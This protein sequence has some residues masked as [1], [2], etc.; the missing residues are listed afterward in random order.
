MVV[1][2]P[3][4]R[5][6]LEGV[7]RQQAW[8]WTAATFRDAGVV[9]CPH[10]AVAAEAWHRSRQPSI[11]PMVDGWTF[12]GWGTPWSESCGA[13]YDWSVLPDGQLDYTNE[14]L[15]RFD[16]VIASVHSHLSMSE[17]EMTAARLQAIHEACRKEVD[18]LDDFS[19]LALEHLRLWLD[20][21][22]ARC[23]RASGTAAPIRTWRW[24]AS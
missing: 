9:L 4:Q 23:L 19:P 11:E 21:T 16:F 13:F 18:A 14:V 2:S 5:N 1:G 12:A 8:D 3:K 22:V 15:A 24:R 17:A 20:V 6:V 10:G 7:S